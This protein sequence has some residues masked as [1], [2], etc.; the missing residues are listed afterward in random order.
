MVELVWRDGASE[1]ATPPAA[2]SEIAVGRRG[3][4]RAGRLRGCRPLLRCTM[5]D[6]KP[7]RVAMKRA[8]AHEAQSL[9]RMA[10]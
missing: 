7:G 10:G 2:C 4:Q 3:A 8:L 5:T 6:T 1:V 9:M